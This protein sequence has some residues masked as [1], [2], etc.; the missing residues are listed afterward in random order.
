MCEEWSKRDPRIKVIHK[1]NGGLSDARNEGLKISTGEFIGFVDSD[2][3]IAPKMYER[4]L[5]M[6]SG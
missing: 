6:S 5:N 2:D 3:W 1:Q 4:L